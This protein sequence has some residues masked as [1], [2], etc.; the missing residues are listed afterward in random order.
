MLMT[1]LKNRK[2]YCFGQKEHTPEMTLDLFL[3]AAWRCEK[4]QWPE[5]SSYPIVIQ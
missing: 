4:G 1:R 5:L 2:P 3:A